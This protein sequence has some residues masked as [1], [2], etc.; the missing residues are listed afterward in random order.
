MHAALTTQRAL[1]GASNSLPSVGLTDVV[2]SRRFH[3]W[4]KQS[5]A[6]ATAGAM[7]L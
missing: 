7:P 6:W 2:Q 4:G 5:K 1:A 3:A